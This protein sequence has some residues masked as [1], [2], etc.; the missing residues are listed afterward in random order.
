MSLHD[1]T[2]AQLSSQ[3]RESWS[4]GLLPYLPEYILPSPI[5]CDAMSAVGR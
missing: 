4:V 5:D 2:T 1:M 3:K